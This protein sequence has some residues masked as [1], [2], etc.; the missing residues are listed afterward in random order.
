MEEP[1]DVVISG[2]LRLPAL[3]EFCGRL[4]S[5]ASRW[6]GCAMPLPIFCYRPNA[7]TSANVGMCA[8]ATLS[9]AFVFKASCPKRTLWI[10]TLERK[11]INEP[12]R[13]VPGLRNSPRYSLGVYGRYRS[14]GPPA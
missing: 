4:G 9:D 6:P 13:L 14:A 10:V 5:S 1:R 3:R 12:R 8:A 7:A 2:L 11:V